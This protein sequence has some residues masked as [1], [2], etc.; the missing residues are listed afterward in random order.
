MSY[1]PSHRNGSQE[2]L[3]QPNS[4]VLIPSTIYTT[5][6]TYKTSGKIGLQ[7]PTTWYGSWTPSITSD[8]IT[9]PSGYYYFIESAQQVYWGAGG[10]KSY[11]DVQVY[12]ETNSQY[13]GQ[14]GKAAYHDYGNDEG[15]TRDRCAFALIDCS[16]SGIDIS[17]RIIQNVGLLSI[18]YQNTSANA[19]Y[20]RTIIWRLDP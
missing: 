9:L 16:S 18:N 17:I 5:T 20:G 14:L 4:L 10:D 7:T 8:V 2:A 3:A 13:I 12:D 19:G 6:A 1:V 11:M 15:N